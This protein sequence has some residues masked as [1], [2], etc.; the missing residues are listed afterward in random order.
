MK[1]IDS[2]SCRACSVKAFKENAGKQNKNPSVQDDLDNDKDIVV[3]KDIR[4]GDT[5]EDG[6]FYL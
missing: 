6:K 5:T 1:G 3:T 4:V 2:K